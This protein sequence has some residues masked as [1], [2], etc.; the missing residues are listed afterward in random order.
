MRVLVSGLG[1]FL[2]L[3]AMLLGRRSVRLTLLMLF[4]IVMMSGLMVM[5]CC[6]FVFCGCLVMM[7][8]RYVFLRHCGIL[9]IC[10]GR[11][12]EYRPRPTQTMWS[13]TRSKCHSATEANQLLVFGC[14]GLAEPQIDPGRQRTLR[15]S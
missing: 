14:P 3:L 6:C 4:L 1:V 12:A 9:Q 11:S 15:R 2:S 10:L 13:S 7:L 8:T 5:V